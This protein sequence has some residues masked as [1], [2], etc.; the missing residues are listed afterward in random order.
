MGEEC[1]STSTTPVENSLFLP[2]A[3]PFLLLVQSFLPNPQISLFF[4]SLHMAVKTILKK[5]YT[6]QSNQRIKELHLKNKLQ[7]ALV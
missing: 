6:D 2:H 3:P 5:I 7:H 1:I 4:R